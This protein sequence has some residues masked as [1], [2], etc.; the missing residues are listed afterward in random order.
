MAMNLGP[1]TEPASSSADAGRKRSAP[2]PSPEEIASCFPQLE[3][4]EC[5]GRGGMGIVY[6]ARQTQLDRFVAL[7]ILSPELVTDPR[8]ADRFQREARALARLNHPNI[9][10]IHDFGRAGDYYFL[11]MEYVDGA[12]LRQVL[13][14]GR[15]NPSEALAIVPSICEAMQYAH[16]QGIV[17]RDIKPENLLMDRQ[18]RVKIADF[19]IARMLAPTPEEVESAPPAETPTVASDLLTQ[20]CILGTPRYMAP[21][22]AQHPTQ[23]DHRADIYSLGVVLYEMLTGE[24][25]ATPLDPPSHKVQVDVRLDEVVLRALQL[26]PEMRY[27]TAKDFGTSI[28]GFIRDPN[29]ENSA[30][31]GSPVPGAP[32]TTAAL[33]ITGYAGI[34][35]LG[36]LASIVGWPPGRFLTG[37]A[38][39]SIFVAG[40]AAWFA[41]RS[42]HRRLAHPNPT[43]A[44]TAR[45]W[46][47]GLSWTARVLALPAIGFSLFFVLAMSQESGGWNPVP[48]EAVVV[49][50]SLAGSILLPWA[51]H[52]LSHTTRLTPRLSNENSTSKP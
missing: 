27:A 52:H 47:R 15:M 16:S 39:M 26:Q 24:L 18:G 35:L 34:L 5:L 3:I 29:N 19:G 51:S 8:F 48:E 30:A 17:H 46:L 7:K 12:T 11:L 25:P 21:E 13:Q 33:W 2:T 44:D 36:L 41:A 22:Q 37:L 43:V 4:K 45:R 20:E 40:G 14:D 49:L 50:S 9:V 1:H 32:R 10:T 42:L 23:V 28:Q 31:M 38:F 6:K